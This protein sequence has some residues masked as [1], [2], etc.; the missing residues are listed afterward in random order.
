MPVHCRNLRRSIQII[1]DSSIQWY[2]LYTSNWFHSVYY[3]CTV[4]MYFF[5]YIHMSYDDVG[6]FVGNRGVFGPR[7]RPRS[8]A[9]GK[10]EK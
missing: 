1:P 2:V 9:V 4:Y 6:I 5:I 3:I 10:T 7:E 8:S